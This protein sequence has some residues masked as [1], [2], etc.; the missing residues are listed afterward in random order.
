MINR[1]LGVADAHNS[2]VRSDIESLLAHLTGRR[3]AVT[4]DYLAAV[5]YRSSWLVAAEEGSEMIVGMITLAPNYIPSGFFGQVADMVVRIDRR[6]KG[7]G[8]KLVEGIVAEARRREMRAL[9]AAIKRDHKG[10]K[11]FTDLGFVPDANGGL[12][13]DISSP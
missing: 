9:A 12:R 3:V 5:A 6:N 4:P 10:A 2:N 7:I 8:H 11:I 13:L 1:F